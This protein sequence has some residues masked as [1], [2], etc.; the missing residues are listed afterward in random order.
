M[1]YLPDAVQMKDAD[2]F[3][4]DTIGI[5]S[6]VLMERAAYA[7][8]CTLKEK[9]K[10]IE[11]ILVVCGSGNNGGDG[12]AVAR[13]LVQEGYEVHIIF[14]GREESCA[15]ETKQQKK[16]AENLGI[17]ISGA[18]NLNRFRKDEYSVIIDALFGIGINRRIEGTYQQIVEKLNQM[19][20]YKAAMDIPSGINGTTGEVMGCAFK[21]ELT[22]TFGF[23]KTGTVLFPG[24]LYA[25]EVISKDIG[26]SKAC[27]EF[28]RRI[29]YTLEKKDLEKI[30]PKRKAD[31]HKGSYGKIF[32]IAGSKGMAGAS[33]LAAKAAYR[34]GAG[35]V[36]IY[37]VK[38][39]L[40]VLQ[41]LIPEAIIEVYEEF[42]KEQIDRCL[43]WADVMAVG[44]GIGQS[45]LSEKIISYVLEKCKTT[46]IIDADG[47]NLL[48]KHSEWYAFSNGSWIVTPHL[49]EMSR[50]TGEAVEKIKK[51][52]FE[53]LETYIL[54]HKVT[55]VL[56]DARTFV[57]KENERGYINTTG[58]AAMA[59]AG[60]GD[61]LTGII[62][63]LAAQ[64]L[65]S[66]EAAVCG[67]LLHGLAGDTKRQEMGA[68][69]VLA[70]DL[71]DGIA[72][73]MKEI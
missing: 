17:S 8:V 50:L 48:A 71:T 3:T 33:F 5:P 15:K 29:R 28:D 68:Y 20:A 12:F 34:A 21:A 44:P 69:S 66:Y 39:N 22:V 40:S 72:Q 11:K 38:E 35:M 36:R 43:A 51:K 31:S 46:C 45:V 65:E 42:D 24:R 27:C 30:L 26:I 47:L 37:T 60:A 57:Q 54:A 58:N 53:V 7:F 2:T 55:C 73:I 61:V 56:K 18:E 52:R 63:G 49:L 32:L 25:G 10:S 4:I 62:A 23:E 59:K 13:M 70:H 16:I 6:M 14:A 19:E 1:R 41:T 67:V 9:I 64:G